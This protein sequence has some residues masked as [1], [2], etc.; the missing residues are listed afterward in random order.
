MKNQAS[1]KTSVAPS[2]TNKKNLLP[3]NSHEYDAGLLTLSEFIFAQSNDAICVQS[4][5]IVGTSGS[6][7]SLQWKGIV[8]R[9]API[10]GLIQKLMPTLLSA[11]LL[12]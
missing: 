6:A 7:V 1:M 9:K 5:Q 8:V 4:S 2:R 11:R 12:Q 10:D 3:Q